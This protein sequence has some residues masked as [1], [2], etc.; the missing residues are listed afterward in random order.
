MNRMADV[1]WLDDWLREAEEAATRQR[2]YV[3]AGALNTIRGNL[4]HVP[5]VEIIRCKDCKY[6]RQEIDM[7]EE[8]TSTAHNIVHEDDFCSMAVKKVIMNE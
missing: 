1:D 2:K 6:Y 5:T 8:M 4:K 3:L 7:C